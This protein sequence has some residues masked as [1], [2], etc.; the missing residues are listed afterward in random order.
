MLS[1]PEFDGP[2]ESDFRDG[3]VGN[4]SIGS[5]FFRRRGSV[6]VDFLFGIASNCS[7]VGAV[8]IM[9]GAGGIAGTDADS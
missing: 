8:V 3:L 6:N 7:M 9:A 5:G 4:G 1:R 2:S